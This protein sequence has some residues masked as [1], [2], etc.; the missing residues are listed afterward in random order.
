M[1]NGTSAG[2]WAMAALFATLAVAGCS[3]PRQ[4]SG[5][6][7]SRLADAALE[8][9]YPQMALNVADNILA[10]DPRNVPALV[11][12]GDAL[13]NSGRTDEAA[14]AY[15]RALAVQPDSAGA[16]GGLGRIMVRSDPHAAERLFRTALASR[17]DDPV[18]LANL[19]VALDLQQRHVE[20][21]AAY[22]HSLQVAPNVTATKAK[23]RKRG[24]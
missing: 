22:R 14:E 20:A 8:A 5:A 2:R 17:P 3:Q 13:I 10:H 24:V 23:D 16:N 9:G 18:L 11:A 19:G 7:T 12:R 21:Q 4:L 6:P 1:D 15:R